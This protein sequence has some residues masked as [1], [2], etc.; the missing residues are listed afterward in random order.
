MESPFHILPPSNWQSK[1]NTSNEIPNEQLFMLPFAAPTLRRWGQHYEN[2]ILE[3]RCELQH[4]ELSLVSI[5]TTTRCVI[6]VYCNLNMNVLQYTLE[7]D[8]WCYLN[9][10]G[11]ALLVQNTSSIQYVSSGMSKLWLNPGTY[12]F[13]YFIL[14]PSAIEMFIEEH[15]QFSEL[16]NRLKQGHNNGLIV[17]RTIVDNITLQLIIKL[18]KVK[19]TATLLKT[20]LHK[21]ISEFHATYAQQ[22]LVKSSE[23]WPSAVAEIVLYIKAFIAEN[24]LSHSLLT[25]ASLKNKFGL[26]KWTIERYWSKVSN[27]SLQAYIHSKRLQLAM[28]LLT[29]EQYAVNE[30]AQLLGYL[31]PSSFTREFTKQFGFSPKY[32][33]EHLGNAEI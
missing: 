17:E 14:P 27:E 16:L 4:Q 25:Y 5:K 12:T 20:E 3:Q 22:L 1:A 28:C 15:T 29:S 6:P 30:V 7:N 18:Q 13:L 9:G 33:K 32:A 11:H 23:T 10:F 26:E 31:E 21:I 19:G 24:I 2:Y 8:A